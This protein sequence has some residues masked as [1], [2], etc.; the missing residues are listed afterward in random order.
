MKL[1]PY[2]SFSA[3]SLAVIWLLWKVRWF[4]L[5][6]ELVLF[7]CIPVWTPMDLLLALLKGL[8]TM[9]TMTVTMKNEENSSRDW[10][11]GDR[12]NI[13]N[14][15]VT[16]PVQLN[17]GPDAASMAIPTPS[18]IMEP[19]LLPSFLCHDYFR[20]KDSVLRDT[21]Y[22]HTASGKL[23]RRPEKLGLPTTFIPSRFR[24]FLLYSRHAR[25]HSSI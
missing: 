4:P 13:H 8:H 19:I 25:D 6:L 12:Q 24:H 2:S 21:T 20:E 1:C 16:D 18:K 5:W 17:D 22:R 11:F 14:Q 10:N 9:L 7:R 15:G 23:P 3:C